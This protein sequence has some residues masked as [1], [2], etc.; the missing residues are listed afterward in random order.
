VIGS[1]DVSPGKSEFEKK[2]AEAM[3]LKRHGSAQEANHLFSQ[4]VCQRPDSV[5]L[6][7]ALAGTYRDLG[8]HDNARRE[9]AKATELAPTMERASKGVFHSLWEMGR[10]SEAISEMKRFMSVADSMDYLE[11]QNELKEKGLL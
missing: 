6:R 11:I 2:F 10:R 4:L 8:E 5:N 1:I 3:E 9:F 7:C